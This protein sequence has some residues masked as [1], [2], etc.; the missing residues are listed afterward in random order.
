MGTVGPNVNT[1]WGVKTEIQS[2]RTKK[3]V[4]NLVQFQKMLSVFWGK[5]YC[6]GREIF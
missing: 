4:K 3:L 6:F 5:K 2:R 1:F